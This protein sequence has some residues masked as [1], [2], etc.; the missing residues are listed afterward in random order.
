MKY[1]ILG[2]FINL[3]RR[4]YFLYRRWHVRKEN[5]LFI[6]WYYESGFTDEKGGFFSA[7]VALL[8]LR[9][10][11]VCVNLAHFEMF[12]ATISLLFA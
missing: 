8:R 6:I 4:F 1:N 9:L 11:D 12:L 2:G 3:H 7:I 10:S 5:Q